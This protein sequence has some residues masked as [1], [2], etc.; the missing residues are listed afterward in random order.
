M[1]RPSGNSNTIGIDGGFHTVF[2]LVSPM[3][4]IVATEKQLT[5]ITERSNKNQTIA[6]SLNRYSKVSRK[7]PLKSYSLSS[8]TRQS[9]TTTTSDKYDETIDFVDQSGCI[10]SPAPQPV[11]TI[12]NISSRY[13][14]AESGTQN[15]LP[16]VVPAPASFHQLSNEGSLR[17]S[18]CLVGSA[19]SSSGNKSK[20]ELPLHVQ[21]NQFDNPLDGSESKLKFS[22]RSRRARS[23]TFEK[24]DFEHNGYLSMDSSTQLPRATSMGGVSGWLPWN[25][26][27]TN[28]DNSSGSRFKSGK[29]KGSSASNNQ[30]YVLPLTSPGLFGSTPVCRNDLHAYIKSLP[31]SHWIQ[32]VIVL[33]A[34]SLVWHA[35]VRTQTIQARLDLFHDKESLSLFH[36]KTVE[37]HLTHLHETVVRLNDVTTVENILPNHHEPKKKDFVDADLI[38]VQTQQLYQMEEELDHE[39]R[40]LQTTIQHVSRSSIVDAY[41]EGPVQVVLELDFQEAERLLSYTDHNTISILLWYDTPHA[42]WTLLQQIQS[43]RWTDATFRIGK[44]SLSIDA[45]SSRKTEENSAHTFKSELKFV[46]KS[47]KTHEPWT[48]GIQQTENGM[49]MFINL[50]D[51]SV[52]HKSDVCVGKVIDGFDALQLLVEASRRAEGTDRA[53]RIKNAT[54]IHLTQAGRTNEFP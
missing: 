27:I 20:Q 4:D 40:T 14:A 50:Q 24:E 26:G 35:Y 32:T 22:L 47:K 28:I 11:R 46:E 13:N 2:P 9:L 17:S 30:E 1:R 16:T 38:R 45:T 31:Q 41:G 25:T 5:S 39:L 7:T 49:G 15:L 36:L 21:H 37:Q 29:R 23:S 48:V 6:N 8:D 34:T 42:A 53:V 19:W 52:V 54:A 3:S 51:N 18:I 44:G 43:G 10:K 33:V 12:K